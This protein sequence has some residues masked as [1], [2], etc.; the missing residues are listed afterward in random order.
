[1]RQINPRWALGA[2]LATLLAMAT[3]LLTVPT[4]HAAVTATWVRQI[5]KP[6]HA[7]LYAWGAATAKDGSI[8]VG[9]YNNYNVKKY[10]TTWPAAADD[11]QQGQQPRADEPALRPGRGPDDR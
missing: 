1:M 10:S 5:G 8:L 7:G 4:A 11:R 6:G 9:D 2:V 3:T